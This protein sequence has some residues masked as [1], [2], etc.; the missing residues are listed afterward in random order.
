[1]SK[2]ICNPINNIHELIHDDKTLVLWLEKQAKD[3]HFNYLLAH[4]EDGVIWG[5][6]E[7]DKLKTAD[8]V[9][10]EDCP[11]LR[12]LTLQQC[13]I[14]GESGEILLWKVECYLLIFPN[15]QILQKC[16]KRRRI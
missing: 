10:P 4:A 7:N 8:I 11:K 12:L 16:L 1:M 3:Y 6:F 14:F 2:E 5:K 15:T 13:R 9:F